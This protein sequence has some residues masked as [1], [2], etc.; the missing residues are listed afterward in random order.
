[1]AKGKKTGGRTKGTLNKAT[2][3]V[4]ELA[5]KHGPKAIKE[6]SRLVTEAE[7][8]QARVSACKELL[9]RAYGKAPQAMEIA[10]KDGEEFKVRDVGAT[11]VARRIAFLLTQ[12]ADDATH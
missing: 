1:M 11:E 12:G 2:E 4:R 7:S 10:N 5:K 9:D 8:E 3:E 6:L